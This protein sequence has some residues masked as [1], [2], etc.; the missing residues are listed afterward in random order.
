MEDNKFTIPPPTNFDNSTSNQNNF[1]TDFSKFSKVDQKKTAD[2]DFNSFDFGK[3]GQQSLS[4]Q[5]KTLSNESQP[6]NKFPQ[7]DFASLGKFSIAPLKK[8]PNSSNVMTQS[9]KISSPSKNI[10]CYIYNK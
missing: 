2:F 3:F 10:D 8:P 7:T 4:P 5:T 9:M 6:E 1:S